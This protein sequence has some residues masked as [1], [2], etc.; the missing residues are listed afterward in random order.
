MEISY[1]N[2]Q[3]IGRLLSLFFLMTPYY[4]VTTTF[5]GIFPALLVTIG[6]TEKY[7]GMIRAEKIAGHR[8]EEPSPD[9]GAR[10]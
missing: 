9:S 8:G 6:V 3:E 4:F 10:N 5:L 1:A 7:A 2:A